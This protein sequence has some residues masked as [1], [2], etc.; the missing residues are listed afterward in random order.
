[1]LNNCNLLLVLQ[2]NLD[3]SF[4]VSNNRIGAKGGYFDP[5]G[6]INKKYSL[7]NIRSIYVKKDLISEG[8]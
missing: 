6:V 2:N 8:T 4:L 1:M 5:S 3:G 7:Q